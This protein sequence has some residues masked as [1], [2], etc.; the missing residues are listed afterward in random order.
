MTETADYVI[1]GAGSAGCVIAER[2]SADPSVRVVLIEAGR[3]DANPLHAFPMLVGHFYR[4]PTDNWSFYTEPQSGLQGRR[5][6]WPRGKRLGGSSIFNG[7]AYARGNAGDYDHWAELGNA[8]W[9]YKDLIPYFKRNERYEDGETSI[10]G[11]SGMLDVTHGRSRNPLFKVFLEAGRQAGYR[12]TDDFSGPDPSGVGYYDF[13]LKNGRRRNSATFLRENGASR[14]NLKIISQALVRRIILDGKRATGVEYSRGGETLLVSARREVV[15]S[16]GAVGTP[17]I[18]MLS[19]IGNAAHL[20]AHGVAPLHD[21]PGVGENL[22]DH[23]DA[24]VRVSTQ[25]PIS[26]LR[27]LRIDRLTYNLARAFLFGTGPVSE[28]VITTGGYFF[29]R[30]DLEY[31]DLQACF[32]PVPATGASVWW[33]FTRRARAVKGMHG[34]GIRIGPIRPKSHGRIT[35][36]SADPTAA[37]LIDPNYLSNE[38]DV[39]ATVSGL[40]IAR[41]LLSQPAFKPFINVETAPGSDVVTDSELADYVRRTGD[42]TYHPVGTAKMGNDPMAVVDARLRVHGIDGLRVADASIMPTIPSGNTNA[43]TMMVAE[44]AS[45]L[46]L[47]NRRPG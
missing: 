9:S 25:Q 38:E 26:L 33:P 46:L 10:H 45:D 4:Q 32:L 17:H 35:L 2:L 29:S 28:S 3:G 14:P 5:L 13:N 16:A 30:D 7:T 24:F 15:L 23:L 19:G 11:G 37:P 36:Q 42:T 1:V 31:P 34:F 20:Q 44:K 47:E 18:L 6:F 21:L 39:V 22:V 27:E 40:K 41:K 12:F 8:G 43:P